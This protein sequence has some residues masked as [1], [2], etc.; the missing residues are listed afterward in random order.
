MWFWVIENTIVVL[1][2][3][4]RGVSFESDERVQVYRNVY[5]VSSINCNESKLKTT[6]LRSNT[7][8]TPKVK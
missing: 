5:V 6:I 2:Y 8:E 4:A 1:F 3:I 7:D